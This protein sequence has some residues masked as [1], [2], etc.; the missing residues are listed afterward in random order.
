MKSLNKWQKW[1]NH[2]QYFLLL[3]IKQFKAVE[4][5]LLLAPRDPTLEFTEIQHWLKP[6]NLENDNL[7]DILK[8]KIKC[9]YKM[10]KPKLQNDVIITFK[11]Y[12]F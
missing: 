10:L 1:S 11:N 12:H 2:F 7:P 8:L 3:L 5:L 9:Y 6:S 4:S